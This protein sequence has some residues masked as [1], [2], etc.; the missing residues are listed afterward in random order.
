MLRIL[1]VHVRRERICQATDLAA[2]HRV[3]LPGDREW[4]HTWLSDASGGEMAID[5]RVDFVR[6]GRRLIYALA[7]NRDDLRR[8]GKQSKEFLEHDVAKA[9]LLDHLQR[10]DR[11]SGPER[12]PKPRCMRSN[13][14][15]IERPAF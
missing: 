3:R 8:L 4:S 5:N 9:C 11:F 14:C 7:E 12:L 10:V 2:T 1:D 15:T 6:P 13:V